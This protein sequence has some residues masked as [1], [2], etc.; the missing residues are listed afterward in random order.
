MHLQEKIFLEMANILKK[1]HYMN[2]KADI[3]GI[4]VIYT[5]FITCE[6]ITNVQV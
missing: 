6:K 2:S 4:T 5:Y 1:I 3:E